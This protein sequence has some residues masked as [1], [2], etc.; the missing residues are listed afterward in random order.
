MWC[1]LTL[2][3]TSEFQDSR[4]QSLQNIHNACRNVLMDNGAWTS[5]H[6]SVVSY[7][8]HGIKWMYVKTYSSSVSFRA[9]HIPYMRSEWTLCAEVE[10]FITARLWIDLSWLWTHCVYTAEWNS[11][12]AIVRQLTPSPPKEIQIRWLDISQ[13]KWLSKKKKTV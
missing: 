4:L 9:W 2:F 13:L 7:R 12:T 6:L 8:L 1:G 11:F 10:K 3:K 5:W